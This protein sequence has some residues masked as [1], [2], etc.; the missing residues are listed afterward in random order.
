[1]FDYMLGRKILEY[2][3]ANQ[4]DRLLECV[5]T[6]YGSKKRIE[7][8]QFL[9]SLFKGEKGIL[10][11]DILN[12]E[13]FVR[14]ID[15]TYNNFLFRKIIYYYLLHQ[16]YRIGE[17]VKEPLR[18]Q[19]GYFNSDED[20]RLVYK[21]APIELF[22]LAP[23]SIDKDDRT[24]YFELYKMEYS[25]DKN[26]E[27]SKELIKERNAFIEIF[28]KIDSNDWQAQ[29]YCQ[30]T[31]DKISKE[32]ESFGKIPTANEKRLPEALEM[33]AMFHDKFL[34]E[35]GLTEDDFTITLD[36][37]SR[38]TKKLLRRPFYGGSRVIKYY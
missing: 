35:T 7:V 27:R 2:D 17:T 5:D 19:L 31:I 4:V 9:E 10:N 38:E 22:K 3:F 13:V 37:T 36:D 16:A 25:E 21:N 28:E 30:Q 18:K 6:Y 24:P 12:S 33:Q 11:T 26:S 8:Q 29:K 20:F 14:V 23:K 1:M 32:L 15:S 34:E